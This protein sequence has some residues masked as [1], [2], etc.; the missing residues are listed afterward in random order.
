MADPWDSWPLPS[1]VPYFPC[2]VGQFIFKNV[3]LYLFLL[4]SMAGASSNAASTSLIDAIAL[5][6]AVLLSVKAGI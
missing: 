5:V 2:I 3:I 4:L 1:P 6:F